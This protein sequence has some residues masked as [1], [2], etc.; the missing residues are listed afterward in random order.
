MF[1]RNITHLLSA[2]GRLQP[3]QFELQPVQVE[4]QSVQIEH[5]TLSILLW[6]FTFCVQFAALWF[7]RK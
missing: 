3:V 5:K 2:K 7:R 4:L 6:L 1:R